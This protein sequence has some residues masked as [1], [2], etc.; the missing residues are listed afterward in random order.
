ME[1]LDLQTVLV[2]LWMHMPMD[3]MDDRLPGLQR[4]TKVTKF[5]LKASCTILMLQMYFDHCFNVFS[6]LFTQYL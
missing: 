4:S 3:S 6:H 1:I 5:F 2:N